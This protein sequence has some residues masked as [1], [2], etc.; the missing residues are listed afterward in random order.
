MIG[1]LHAL[2]RGGRLALLELAACG[3][4][5]SSARAQVAAP[6]LK[7]PI[8]VYDSGADPDGH[9]GHDQENRATAMQELAEAA[10]LKQAG[11]RL[12]G[13][14]VNGGWFAPGGGYR[15]W[16]AA[17]WPKGPEAWIRQCRAQGI[18]P[19]LW[20]ATNTLQ[21]MSAAPAWRDSLEN[22]GRAMSMF[23]GGFLADFMAVLQQWYDRGVRIFGLGAV[24]LTAVTTEGAASLSGE[25]I[26]EHNAAALGKAL[27]EFRKKNPAA[28]LL[29]IERQAQDAG[30]SNVAGTA[31]GQA[32]LGGRGVFNLVST[33][34]ELTAEAPEVNLQRSLDIA[35]DE[36]VRRLEL[37]GIPLARIASPGVVVG[38]AGSGVDRNSDSSRGGDDSPRD[39]GAGFWKSSLL[40]ALARGG[41][42]NA[43]RGNLEL[44]RGGDAVWM[45]RVQ[46]L[47]LALAAQ[48]G[49]H[50]FGGAPNEDEAYGFAGATAR[51]AVYVVMNPGQTM[52]TL[53]FPGTKASAPG[54]VQFCDA[55]FSPRLSGNQITLGPG[56]MAMVGYGIYAQPRFNFGVQNRVVIPKSIEPVRADFKGA[57]PGV[58]EAD[59]EPPMYGELRV[60]M[61]RRG[62]EGSGDA[63]VGNA[64][65]GDGRGDEAITVEATQNGRSIPLRVDQD[66]LEWSGITWAVTEIDVND[67]TPGLPV[68]VRFH[69]KD[70]AGKLKGSAYQVEY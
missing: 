27:E 70:D 24:D 41:G 9:S 46:R 67:L 26:R 66:A 15:E 64:R 29:V 17:E 47:F 2:R 12:D 11:V 61:Q 59:V 18:R 52:A 68:E 19:G 32:V 45:A 65:P 4:W 28:V 51:G 54:R 56:E 23:E 6:A 57:L 30:G 39:R 8:F 36:A 63:A 62:R 43:V 5:I 20:F 44:I 49:M 7:L 48:G 34:P 21:G 35:T 25:Q 14:L 50:S 37:S 38:Q 16:R 13:F 3:V 1:R 10:R 33:G 53:A 58:I 22:D 55:G 40:L 42:M 60:M 31:R 69:V